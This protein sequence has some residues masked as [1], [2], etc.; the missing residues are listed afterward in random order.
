MNS[1]EKSHQYHISQDKFDDNSAFRDN[2]IGNLP[3]QITDSNRQ[4]VQGN[5]KQRNASETDSLQENTNDGDNNLQ[6]QVELKLDHT[7]AIHSEKEMKE[8]DNKQGSEPGVIKFTINNDEIDMNIYQS[9][10]LRNLISDT[11]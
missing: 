7:N 4:G 10:P 6:L 9:D 2:N 8:G 3:N 11:V 1:F 5:Y